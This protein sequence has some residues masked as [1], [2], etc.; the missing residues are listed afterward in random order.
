MFSRK[1]TVRWSDLDANAH[2]RNTAYMEYAMQVR[3]AF[4]EENGFPVAEFARFRFGPVVFRDELVYLKEL[5][6]LEEIE[7]NLLLAGLSSDGA[8][9]VL[10]NHIFR[11]ADGKEAAYVRSEG[12]WLNLETRKLMAPPEKL[13]QVLSALG[14][15]GSFAE[16]AA[17]SK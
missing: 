6:L 16:M 2:M 11:A 5:H 12:A 1:F 8:R 15:T 7:V 3:V 13:H 14:R 17:G 4:F 9:F 10:E